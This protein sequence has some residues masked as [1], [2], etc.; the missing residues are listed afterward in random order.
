MNVGDYVRTKYGKIGKIIDFNKAL[1]FSP[2][3][4]KKN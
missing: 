1:V 2:I 4:L 3:L